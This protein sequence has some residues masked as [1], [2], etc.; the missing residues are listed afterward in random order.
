MGKYVPK[1]F[2]SITKP[3]STPTNYF[4]FTSDDKKQMF[5]LKNIQTKY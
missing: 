2:V 5:A 4:Y 3:N 1:Q